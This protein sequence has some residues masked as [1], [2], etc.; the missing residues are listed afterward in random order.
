MSSKS[1]VL[2]INGGTKTIGQ[3]FS[4]YNTMGTEE[5][6]AASEVVKS[7][8]LS[9]FVG[10]PGK[11]FLGG[12]YVKAFES[13]F[14]NRFEIKNTVSVNSWTSGLIAMVGA[15]GIEPGDEVLVSPW[16]MCASAIA[17]L[18]WNAIPVFVDIDED[19]FCIDPMKIEEKIT[20][21]TRAILVV[22][23]FGQSADMDPIL[24]L[25]KNMTSK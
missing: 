16:T 17:I 2:A 19:T 7:G 13:E 11:N 24:K 6:E 9:D 8:V 12:H 25:Q 10:A 14:K 18:H 3:K 20:S 5:V 21:R 23:I 4:V 1:K 22:D 15:L